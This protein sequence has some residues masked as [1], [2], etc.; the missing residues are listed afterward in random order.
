MSK[1]NIYCTITRLNRLLLLVCTTM[2]FFSCKNE[3]ELQGELTTIKLSPAFVS[4]NQDTDVP[5]SVKGNNVKMSVDPNQ[6]IYAIQAYENDSAYYYG[7]FDNIDSMKIAVTTGKTYRFKIATYKTSTGNGLKQ[8][9]QT[10]GKYFYLP[11]KTLLGNKFIKGNALKDI[12]LT[13]SIKLTK[14][15]IKDYPEID[16]HY[17]DKSLTM[18]KG[19]TN[20]DFNLLRMG[21]GVT[22]YVDGLTNGMLNIYMGDDTIHLTPTINKNGSVRLF[23]TTNGDF[24]S[25]FKN[26]NTF[27]DSISIQVQWAGTN[28]TNLLIQKKFLFS[29][30]YQKTIN[31]QLNTSSLNLNFEGW[32][33]TLTDVDGNVYKIVTIG[34]QTWMAENLKVTHYRDGTAIPNITDNA[35]WGSSATG[36]YCDYSNST[37]NGT[38]YGHLYN[39]YAAVDSRNIAPSGWHVPTDIEWK[40]LENYLIANGYNYDGAKS[41]NKIAKS[42]AAK[43]YWTNNTGIGTVG[44]DSTKNNAAGFNGFPYGYRYDFNGLSYGFG[45]VAVWWSSTNLYNESISYDKN[46]SQSFVDGNV[47]NGYKH[48]GIAIRCV[49]D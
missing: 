38:K 13:S 31:I 16:V 47:V 7:L 15:T 26:A 49:K 8:D 3:S 44:N 37:T 40:T 41:E 14:T 10:E 42:L 48:Y 21:F 46:M 39:W 22:Y 9:V 28:G 20:I 2:L 45:L 12:N 24:N 18:T 17:C 5:M 43:T 35:N 32:A 29:R 11:N 25:I 19:V 4:L 34:S 30:N 6:V 36:A 33:N 23:K 1:Q 27:S